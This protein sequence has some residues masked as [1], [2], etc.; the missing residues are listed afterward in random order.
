[1]ENDRLIFWYSKRYMA[2][3]CAYLGHQ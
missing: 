3:A 1:M 2:F